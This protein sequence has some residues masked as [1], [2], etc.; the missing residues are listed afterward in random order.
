MS[1]MGLL[2]PA[3]TETVFRWN[4]DITPCSFVVWK[5]VVIGIFALVAMVSGVTYAIMAIV[6]EL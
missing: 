5:N 2:L 4:R 6:K 1:V 3:I